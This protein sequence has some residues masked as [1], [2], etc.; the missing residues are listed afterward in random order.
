MDLQQ[1]YSGALP[2]FIGVEAANDDDLRLY[3]KR[4]TL[5]ET[6]ELLGF[7]KR[8][9]NRV[10]VS[11]GFIMFNPFST[12][13]RLKSNY[14]FLANN[15]TYV[16]SNYI[17]RLYIYPGTKMYNLCKEEGILEKGF[18]SRHPLNYKILDN[19]VRNIY[20]YVVKELIPF[21]NSLPN[22]I[23]IVRN[24]YGLRNILG[25]IDSKTDELFFEVLLEISK[26]LKDFFGYLFISND[27]EKC[28]KEFPA[29]TKKII[30]NYKLINA[31]NMKY[32]IEYIRKKKIGD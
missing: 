29:W 7:L 20:K 11:C 4:A 18:D 3:G 8:Y 16:L 1:L 15:Q 31:I 32:R 30:E 12:M 5:Q 28:R 27:I 9:K 22:M 13:E 26:L 21:Q 24:I 14:L 6:K 17:S 23:D 10:M 19:N 25:D 2:L